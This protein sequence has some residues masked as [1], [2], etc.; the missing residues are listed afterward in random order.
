MASSS[1]KKRY[2]SN[3]HRKGQP[4]CPFEVLKDTSPSCH[5]LLD[6]PYNVPYL[7]PAMETL[8]KQRVAFNYLSSSFD[9]REVPPVEWRL[10]TP[11]IAVRRCYFEIDCRNDHVECSSYSRTLDTS[12]II[13][14]GYHP[15]AWGCPQSARLDGEASWVLL[16]NTSA[17]C[18]ARHYLPVLTK[19]DVLQPILFVIQPASKRDSH[20]MSDLQLRSLKPLLITWGWR[21]VFLPQRSMP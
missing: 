2:V 21:S 18:T 8:P 9:W 10:H 11:C 4:T 12:L 3:L 19:E 6:T 13:T 17:C 5:H 14:A 15:T 7:I 20:W 16:P 1:L